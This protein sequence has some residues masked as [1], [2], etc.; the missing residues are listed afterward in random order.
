[1][2][3]DK[4]RVRVSTPWVSTVVDMRKAPG[5]AITVRRSVAAGW[6][7]GR[8]RPAPEIFEESDLDMAAALAQMLAC[9]LAWDRQ[10]HTPTR[11]WR[12]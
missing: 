6:H 12:E 11:G 7:P 1:M 8:G 5:L 9:G 4:S 2:G 3:H 10:Q